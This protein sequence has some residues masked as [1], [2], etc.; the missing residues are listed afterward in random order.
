[1]TLPAAVAPIAALLPLAAAVYFMIASGA[2][3]NFLVPP[4][5]TPRRQADMFLNKMVHK[6]YYEDVRFVSLRI[7]CFLFDFRPWNP[8]GLDKDTQYAFLDYMRTLD[9]ANQQAIVKM[10]M[11]L[12]QK[13]I[14]FRVRFQ[15]NKNLPF[16]YNL[17]Q[18]KK[19]KKLWNLVRSIDRGQLMAYDLSKDTHA[20]H[21]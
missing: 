19:P 8:D 13:E 18:M 2:L 11:W 9:L 5:P 7:D 20:L 15:W 14:K 12:M 16:T 3:K 4:R 17:G 21:P 1:M 10:M 6:T